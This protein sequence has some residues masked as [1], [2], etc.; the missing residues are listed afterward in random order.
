MCG[1]SSESNLLHHLVYQS[2]LGKTMLSFL[3]VC[4]VAQCWKCL[5]FSIYESR[6]DSVFKLLLQISDSLSHKQKKKNPFLWSEVHYYSISVKGWTQMVCQTFQAS[7][8]CLIL[9]N[10]HI[11]QLQI[12]KAIFKGPS[13]TFWACSSPCS[14]TGYLC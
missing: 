12:F 3:E 1:S 13:S 4:S 11:W 2:I 14:K 9:L 8:Y 5:I 10:Q 6:W 7:V